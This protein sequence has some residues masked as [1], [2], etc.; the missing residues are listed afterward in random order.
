M[1]TIKVEYL[2][3]I[4]STTGSVNNIKIKKFVVSGSKN[5]K[6]DEI[7]TEYDKQTG[8]CSIRTTLIGKYIYVI[9]MTNMLFNNLT[10]HRT[11]QHRVCKIFNDKDDAFQFL[12]SDVSGEKNKFDVEKQQF[13]KTFCEVDSTIWYT[14]YPEFICQ[15]YEVVEDEN[16]LNFKELNKIEEFTASEWTFT[17]VHSNNKIRHSDEDIKNIL[18]TEYGEQRAIDMMKLVENK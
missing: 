17:F 8:L 1:I 3:Y 16:N 6:C 4:N 9:T 18:S 15:K 2:T 12:R 14:K 11:T 13:I 7:K 10:N 5:D